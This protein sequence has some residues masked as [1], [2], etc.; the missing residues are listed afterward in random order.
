VLLEVLRRV[1]VT[2]AEQLVIGAL[3]EQI[4]ANVAPA[5]GRVV[6]LHLPSEFLTVWVLRSPAWAR[7]R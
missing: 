2:L 1:P 3:L 5:E 7:A 6:N 4:A